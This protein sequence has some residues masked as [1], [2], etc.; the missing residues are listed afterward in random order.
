[1]E[2]GRLRRTIGSHRERIQVARNLED[3]AELRVPSIAKI[4]GCATRVETLLI[5]SE[6]L[7]NPPLWTDAAF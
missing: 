1:M 4:H 6:Q 5:T 7:E 3:M 2:L